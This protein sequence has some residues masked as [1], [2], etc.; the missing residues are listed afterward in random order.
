MPFPN[1]HAARLQDPNKFDSF[2]RVKDGTHDLPGAKEAKVP[3]SVSVIIANK[4]GDDSIPR[5]PQSLRFPLSDWTEDAAKT[6]L[7]DNGVNEILFEPA[8][9]GKALEIRSKRA[10][11]EIREPNRHAR[12]EML[13]C[14][15]QL[16]AKAQVALDAQ[17]KAKSDP[18]FI[19]GYAA[20]FNNIDLQDE[21]IV[22]GAFAKSIQERVPAGKVKLMAKHFAHGGDVQDLVGTVTEMKEDDFG[23]WFHSVV[24]RSKFAQEIRQDVVDGHI[25]A[26]SIGFFPIAWGF[27]KVDGR[28][29]IE[30]T[31]SQALEVT[32]T[33]RPANELALIT[34]AKSLEENFQRAL[35]TMNV[36]EESLSSVSPENIGRMIER[37]FGSK[38]VAEQFCVSL[39]LIQNQLYSLLNTKPQNIKDGGP[40]QPKT[41]KTDLHSMSSEVENYRRRLQ[42]MK[43][44][45]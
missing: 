6:W 4:I 23:L 40:D 37:R 20:V 1:E 28:Q 2:F 8:T 22:K 10:L 38:S 7:K 44:D 17:G 19:Q 15:P 31:E 32:L 45:S 13:S 42:D 26:N 5:Q 21:R 3:D 27:V 14:D 33:A 16:I 12:N 18:G 35:D 11:V 43:L 29:I 25:N 9:G 30:H 34:G 39:A 24:S 36:F 41:S